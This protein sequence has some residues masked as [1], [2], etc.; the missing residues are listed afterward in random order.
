L[1]MCAELFSLAESSIQGYSSD[2]ASQ[3]S[4]APS[5]KDRQRQGSPV[6]KGNPPL[7]VEFKK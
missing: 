1:D 7:C 6:E 3:G 2:M 5:D 4:Q